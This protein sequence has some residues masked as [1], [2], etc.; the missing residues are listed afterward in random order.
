MT[1]E[2]FNN[3]QATRPQPERGE[4]MSSLVSERG[5]QK[6]INKQLAEENERL[7][8]SKGLKTITELGEWYIVD[9]NNCIVAWHCE[10]EKL[11]REI[12]VLK[13]SESL[14]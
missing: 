13:P 7:V 12:G 3:N 2:Q 4:N 11:A 6:R 9:F 1:A 14:A 8:K 5:L 10:I